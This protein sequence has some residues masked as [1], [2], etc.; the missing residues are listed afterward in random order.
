MKNFDSS[1]LKLVGLSHFLDQQSSLDDGLNDLVTQA[2][3]IV[4]TGNCSIM[5][6]HSDGKSDGFRLRI[7]AH[8][9]PLPDQALREA[10]KVDE[11]I[12]GRVA[13]SGRPLLVED[14]STS[15]YL[16]LARCPDQAGKSFICVPIHCG[17]KV[18]GV[19]NFSNPGTKTRLDQDDLQ[20]ANFVAL[21]VG[22]SI[23]V[24]ELQKVLRS[25]FLQLAIARE[26][27]A[28]VND[29]IVPAIQDANRLVKIVARTFYREMT[30]AGFNTSQIVDAATEVIS[31]LSQTLEK[32]R[33]RLDS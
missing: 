18:V 8:F 16:P 30:N 22:K 10:A 2:A 13:A 5:L 27:E 12:A 1:F 15:S 3:G 26:T 20:L 14:I 31:L 24:T 32:H 21:L 33:K 29:T 7:F 19:I 6:L 11:G 4:D 23:H 17:G 9:G 28:L 25:R